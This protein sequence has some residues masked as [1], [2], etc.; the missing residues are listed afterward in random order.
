MADHNPDKF[1]LGV[2]FLGGQGCVAVHGH[3]GYHCIKNRVDTSRCS[4]LVYRGRVNESIF[5]RG[6]QTLDRPVEHVALGG[7]V[8]ILLRLVVSLHAFHSRK[9]EFQGTVKIIF[10]RRGRKALAV[11]P[12]EYSEFVQHL[13][14]LLHVNHTRREVGTAHIHGIMNYV[15][16]VVEIHQ[17]G[18]VARNLATATV[19]GTCIV[20]QVGAHRPRQQTV[21]IIG[22]VTLLFLDRT[23]SVAVTEVVGNHRPDVVAAGEG[24]LVHRQHHDIVEIKVARL[25]NPHNLQSFQRGTVQIDRARG[26]NALEHHKE[27]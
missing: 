10:K 21:E 16:L 20:N 5:I 19:S 25:Q 2:Q 17:L 3:L 15:A 7:G 9:I 13:R 6:E 14:S 24:A 22:I 4:H 26:Q 27:R 23:Q 1:G 18:E 11:G 8:K 12:G